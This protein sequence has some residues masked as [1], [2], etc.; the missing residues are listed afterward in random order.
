MPAGP[1]PALARRARA[2]CRARRGSGRPRLALRRSAAGYRGSGTAPR[3]WPRRRQA[4]RAG[5]SGCRSMEPASLDLAAVAQEE[6]LVDRRLGGVLRLAGRRGKLPDEC[7]DVS[8]E[9]VVQPLFDH[10]WPAAPAAVRRSAKIARILGSWPSSFSST[11]IR[12]WTTRPS[13]CMTLQASCSGVNVLR[14]ATTKVDAAGTV[15]ARA[16]AG[17]RLARS[18]VDAGQGQ[19]AEERLDVVAHRHE[20]AGQQLEQLGVG[21]RVFGSGA[22]R[23]GAPAR[24]PSSSP[25]GG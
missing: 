1:R 18:L 13:P 10:R 16:R 22:G 24:G 2:P 4:P 9:L 6:G 7:G 23:P 19:L 8:L 25:R 14:E 12:V 17:R 11:C 21:G 15:V 3:R 20:L 5:R